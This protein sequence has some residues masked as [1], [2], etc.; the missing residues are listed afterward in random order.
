MERQS[1]SILLPTYN[2]GYILSRAIESVLKQTFLFWELIIIDDGSSDDTENIVKNFS[3][4]IRIKYFKIKHQGKVPA[5]N[6]GFGKTAYEIISFIDSDDWYEKNHLEIGLNCFSMNPDIDFVTTKLTVIGDQFVVDARDITKKINIED[7][8]P[9]GT[10]FVKRNVVEELGGFPNEEYRSDYLFYN[11]AKNSGKIIS[12]LDNRTYF[13][14]RTG[15]DSVTKIKMRE[16][17]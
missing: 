8:K 11:L 10:F 6:Y 12:N 5:L 2:R 4:D 16:C 9:Q 1:V 3:Y 13:Y 7:C 14:D 17:F 15:S